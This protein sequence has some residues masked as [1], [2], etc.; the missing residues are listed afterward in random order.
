M[1]RPNPLVD[2]LPEHVK[3]ELAAE[4]QQL[5]R[6]LPPMNVARQKFLNRTWNLYN[7]R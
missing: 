7:Y 1:T 6:W 2:E 5:A 4:F 3:A